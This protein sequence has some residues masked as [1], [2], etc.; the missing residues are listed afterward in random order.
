MEYMNIAWVGWLII[1]GIAVLI[2]LFTFT[3]FFGFIAITSALVTVLA[4]CFPATGIVIQVLIWIIASICSVF[5]W[6]RLFPPESNQWQED[7]IGQEGFVVAINDRKIKAIF[8]KPIHGETDWWVHA[9]EQSPLL[10]LDDRVRIVRVTHPDTK[11]SPQL[12]V[13]KMA[14]REY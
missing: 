2:E 6:K 7:P 9:T 3:Y 11:T 1:T 8:Q 12:W 10:A 13:E 5:V 14:K 4:F